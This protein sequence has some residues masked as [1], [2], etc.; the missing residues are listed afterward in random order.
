M[1]NLRHV[2][3]SNYFPV[4]K[5]SYLL[6]CILFVTI[7][8]SLNSFITL[9]SYFGEE[10]RSELKKKDNIFLI[11][12]IDSVPSLSWKVN[13]ESFSLSWWL[14]RHEGRIIESGELRMKISDSYKF[15][16]GSQEN[17]AK[18]SD[19]GTLREKL[20]AQPQ[21][22]CSLNSLSWGILNYSVYFW[23]PGET[24][25]LFF[26]LMK[27]DNSLSISWSFGLHSGK[28]RWRNFCILKY[29]ET[30]IG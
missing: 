5:G 30:C 24:S 12:F 13:W 27:D 18:N 2:S 26:P 1:E 23:C 20:P 3:H 8:G 9:L 22:N 25:V 7:S 16:S 11:L 14:C 10:T 28:I 6:F 17:G 29:R 15:A 21:R 4:R 19:P